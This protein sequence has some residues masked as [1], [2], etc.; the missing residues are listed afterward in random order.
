MMRRPL[1][2]EV[3]VPSPRC[4]QLRYFRDEELTEAFSQA[5]SPG[6]RPWLVMQPFFTNL[7]SGASTANCR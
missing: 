2:P 3:D 4:W 1:G 6:K 7:K 5:S